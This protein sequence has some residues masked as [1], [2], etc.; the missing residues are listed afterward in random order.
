MRSAIATVKILCFVVFCIACMPFL[1]IWQLLFSRTQIYTVPHRWIYKVVCLIFRVTVTTKGN[2]SKDHVVFVGNHLSYI[3]IIAIGSTLRTHFISKD[4]VK[5]W[6]LFGIMAILSD[7]VFISRSRKSVSKSINDISDKL[8]LN[9]RLV[10]FAEGTSSRGDNVLPFKSSLFELFLNSK[11]KE[12][13]AIQPF[14]LS[15]QTLNSLPVTNPETL[16]QYSYYGDITMAPH[17]WSFAKGKGA[18]IILKFHPPIQ[19]SEFND[20]KEFATMCHAIVDQG[21]REMQAG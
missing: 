3:D 7:T 12:K 15:V 4:D 13:I 17:L 20:R 21:L 1:F 5:S 16:D 8:N 18:H 6:P 2:I 9:R 19:A 14:T 11:I 10:L